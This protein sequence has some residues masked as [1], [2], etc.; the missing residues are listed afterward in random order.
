MKKREELLKRI[1]IGKLIRRVRE[2]KGLKQD[3]FAKDLG[4]SPSS[5]R[6]ALCGIEKGAQYV[7][8]KRILKVANALGIRSEDLEK[9]GMTGSS[10]RDRQLRDIQLEMNK[11]RIEIFK[12]Q[13]RFDTNV[14]PE[15]ERLAK[16][17]MRRSA[18]MNEDNWA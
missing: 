15:R 5:S 3:A 1:A 14:K 9:C 17:Q 16:L 10:E 4:I 8:F 18:I 6:I 11:V 13:E 12:K 2:S 7:S